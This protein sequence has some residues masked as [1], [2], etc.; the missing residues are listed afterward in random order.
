MEAKLQSDLDAGLRKAVGWLETH[1]EEFKDKPYLL[2]LITYALTLAD[3]SKASTGLGYLEAL[4]K[5]CK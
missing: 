3:S 4:S 5:T 1:L 2:A